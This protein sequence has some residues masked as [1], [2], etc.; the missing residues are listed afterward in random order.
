M[1]PQ[2][3]KPVKRFLRTIES[4]LR[5]RC[6]V[7]RS[8]CLVL[9][10]SGGMDSVAMLHA[11]HAISL[12]DR[13][14]LKLI[15]AH[16]AHH[17][18]QRPDE[19]VQADHDF[20]QQL[21]ARLNLEFVSGSGE[22]KEAGNLENIARKMRYAFMQNV[23]EAENATAI[24]TAHHADDQAE[25]M[26]MRLARGTSVRGLS[27][28][29]WSRPISKASSVRLI[30]PMLA[31]TR[32]DIRAYASEISESWCEDKTNQQSDYLRNY[33]RHDVMGR[34]K[35]RLP[36]LG[37][38]A[39]QLADHLHEVTHLLD[40]LAD[41]LQSKAICNESEQ[42]VELDRAVLMLSRR[43]LV[44]WMLRRL[45][46]QMDVKAD[47]VNSGQMQKLVS[48]CQKQSGELREFTFPTVDGGS[49]DIRIQSKH[50]QLRRK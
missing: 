36:N 7:S 31:T 15:V 37:V 10:V 42:T 19:H 12:H 8:D 44:S 25:T 24:V 30:R 38:K 18:G 13:W 43:S 27:A 39:S 2:S 16:F 32:E 22:L 45:M 14:N 4:S 17:F 9:A 26:F 23:A 28:M 40:E 6:G 20:V 5:H 1:S 48:S 35:S 47:R 3:S 50:V 46:L 49:V 21:S 33:I 11:M 41:E 34:L 29:R